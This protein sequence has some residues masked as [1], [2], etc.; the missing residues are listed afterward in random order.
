VIGTIAA[1][2]GLVN[3]GRTGATRVIN[4]M[5]GGLSAPLRHSVIRVNAATARA[6]ATAKCPARI[7]VQTSGSRRRTRA[8]GRARYSVCSLQFSELKTPN[9]GY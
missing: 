6:I 5:N 3:A 1:R 9:T 8:A 4:P 7:D 2:T